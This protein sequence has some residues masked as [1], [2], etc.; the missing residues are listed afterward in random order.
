VEEDAA[1]GRR[2]GKGESCEGER[3]S[4]EFE[5]Q[6]SVDSKD[7]ISFTGCFLILFP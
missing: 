4:F 6:Q 1:G 7:K 5:S 2:E 3:R